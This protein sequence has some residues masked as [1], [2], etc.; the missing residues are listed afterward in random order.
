MKKDAHGFFPTNKNRKKRTTRNE[1]HA[2]P[3]EIVIRSNAIINQ[4]PKSKS[5]F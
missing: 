5:N 2:S 4:P 3:F 1:N